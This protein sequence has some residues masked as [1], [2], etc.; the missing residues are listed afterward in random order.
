MLKC[1]HEGESRKG[2]PHM[3]MLKA[4]AEAF[5]YA[6]TDI[7][8]SRDDM[9]KGR[10]INLVC[11]LLAAFYNVFIGGIFYTGFLSMND[12]DIA[13][14]GIVMFI[15]YIASLCSIFS[16][17]VI[18]RFRR[19]KL[20]LVCAKIYFYAMYIVATTAMPQFV[21]DPHAR[22][23]W[24]IVILFL[25]YSVYA[26]FS[27]GITV[28][29]YQFYPKDNDRRTRYFQLCQ[30]FSS[31]MSTIILLLSGII[32]DAVAGSPHQRDLIIGLRLLAFVLVVVETMVQYQAK[33]FSPPTEGDVKLRQVFTLP[34]KYRKF[35]LCISFMF[36][37]NYIANL[38]NGLWNYHLLNHMHFPYTLI[39]LMSV[40]YTFILLTTS[41]LWRRVLIRFSWIRTFAIGLL[42][43]VP[44]EIVF[45]FM[46][47]GRAY[48]FV[49]MCFV[50][51]LLS[52]GL[53]LSYSNILYMNLPEENS[54]S[55][56]AFYSIGC[57]V[58]AFLGLMTGT[59]VSAITG[60]STVRAFG[61]DLYSVQYTTLMRGV[62]ILAL[63][64]VLMLRWRSFTRD[65]DIATLDENEAVRKSLAA[66]RKAS[67]AA[68]AR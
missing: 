62:T 56:I 12:I 54:T 3:Q 22:L 55:H 4:R 57:N 19:R 16:S 44:T 7:F 61:M 26:P 52:V 63:G 46:T 31:I 13:G 1:G 10:T 14:A 65:E 45:F 50:Q 48:L 25:A 47:P 5:R 11:T 21:T 37:W 33:D 49:P 6:F 17:K 67:R 32:T 24:F 36:C 53:N 59:A 2:E 68:R 41:P 40:M 39:N 20:A 64:I 23:V 42:F 27:P 35:I 66:R 8:N 15:P 38:N 60:D 34:F 9:A 18:S 43:W 58:C 51:N 30:I 28:W 29:F